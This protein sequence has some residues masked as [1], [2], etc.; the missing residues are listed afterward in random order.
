MRII[1]IQTGCK[2]PEI[3]R[4]QRKYARCKKRQQSFKKQPGSGYSRTIHNSKYHSFRDRTDQRKN[5]QHQSG[6]DPVISKKSQP[7]APQVTQQAAHREYRHEKHTADSHQKNGN[8]PQGQRHLHRR[9]TQKTGAQKRRNSQA[10]HQ[11]RGRSTVH[12]GKPAAEN[13]G[14]RT[15]DTRNDGKDLCQSGSSC[16]LQRHFVQFKHMR[17]SDIP[18]TQYQKNS[19]EDGNPRKNSR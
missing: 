4:H 6:D 11:F 5:Q 10:A 2:I 9:Q 8:T 3:Q 18:F 13:C 12:P 1:R 7:A 16:L 14:S 19:T 15:G 17:F